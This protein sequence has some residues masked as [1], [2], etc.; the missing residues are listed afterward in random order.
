MTRLEKLNECLDI[1]RKFKNPDMETNLL[2]EIE[3]ERQNPC[4]DVYPDPTDD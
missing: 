2:R 1:A 4:D 3:N